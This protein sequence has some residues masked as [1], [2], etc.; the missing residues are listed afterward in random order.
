MDY[1]YCNIC[2][3]HLQGYGDYVFKNGKKI[4]KDC[5]ENQEN[6]ADK[7]DYDNLVSYIKTLF[8]KI[9]LPAGWKQYLDKQHKLGKTYSGMQGSLYYFYEIK[10]NPRD[11]QSLSAIGIIEYVYSEVRNYFEEM[12]K[13]NFFNVHFK[14]TSQT[15]TYS[16][17]PPAV[18]KHNIDIGDL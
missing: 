5:L 3:K 7:K 8:H 15:K 9:E 1:G 18:K 2:K 4:C 10:N 16:I 14:D 13:T 12:E 11:F 6:E 17:K